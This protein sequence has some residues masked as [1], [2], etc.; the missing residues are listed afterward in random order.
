MAKKRWQ[1]PLLTVL[2][3]VKQD[4]VLTTDCKHPAIP[5]GA[6]KLNNECQEIRT[7]P[8]DVCSAQNNKS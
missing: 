1:K 7:N 2:L 8:C 4:E 3:R 6:Q 5:V